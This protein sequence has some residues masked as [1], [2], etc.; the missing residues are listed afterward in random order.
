M[1]FALVTSSAVASASSVLWVHSHSPAALR[2]PSTGL[3]M[4]KITMCWRALASLAW[5]SL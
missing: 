5:Q 1:L 4:P 2:L 3:V